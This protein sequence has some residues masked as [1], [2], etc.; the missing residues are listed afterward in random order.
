MDA[1]ATWL[2]SI[3]IEAL[4]LVLGVAS[5]IENIFP[6]VPADVFVALGSFLAAQ[7]GAALLPTVASIVIGSTIGALIVYF[8]AR[9]LGAE[10]LHARLKKAGMAGY[11]EKLTVAYGNYGTLA[12]FV[13]RFVPGIRA[14]VTPVAG[15]L[16]VPVG[17][18]FVVILVASSV[19]Y[20]VIGG[21]A[22]KV[23]TDWEDVRTRITHLG[24][25]VSLVAAL[26]AVLLALG[27]VM[28]RRRRRGRD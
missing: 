10:W 13:S 3:P 5:V 1:V 12:L 26:V 27:F 17:R 21:L 20:G 28:L 9:R 16:R 7:R 23:G 8:I 19:W 14:L 2:A 25:T 4:Y 11:E 18:F 24:R 15:A 22:Y 6:P